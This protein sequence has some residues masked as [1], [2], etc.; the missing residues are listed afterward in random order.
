MKVQ[1]VRT[2]MIFNVMTKLWSMVSIYLFVPLYLNILGEAA[3][4]LISIFSTLQATLN[5]LGLGLS[6]TL[7]REFAVGEENDINNARKYKLLKS[8]ELI[9]A[10]IAIIIVALCLFGSSFIANEWLNI[11]NLDALQVSRVIVLMGV[12]I[13]LQLVAS[14]YSGCLLGLEHQA[15][16]NSYCIV[17]SALKSIGALLII[18]FVKTDL[19]YFYTWHITVDIVYILVLRITLRIKCPSNEKWRFKDLSNLKTIWKYTLGILIISFVALINRQYDKLIISKF[20]SITDV[21]AYNVA[22]TLGSI[23]AIIPS[24]LYT[25]MFPKFTN[26]V[27]TGDYDKLQTA[28]LGANRFTNIVLMCMGSFIAIYAQELIFVWTGSETYQE[29]LGLAGT[30]IV[31]AITFL[32]LQEIPYA[33][34]LSHGN[35]KTNIVVG[36]AFLPIVLVS[37]FLGVYF[38]GILGASIVY[39]VMMLSQSTAYLLLIYKKYLKLNK[40]PRVL[41]VDTLLPFFISIVM[42]IASKFLIGSITSNPYLQAGFAVLCGLVAL[43]IMYLFFIRNKTKEKGEKKYE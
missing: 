41:L 33:L 8:V 43:I 20:L 32:E 39:F 21:G 22:N 18:W 9:Y 2:N 28:F 37:M 34:A 42:A 15:L 29:K 19:V 11:E 38:Y 31:L 10:G 14:M 26:Y 35:T 7:G 40:V 4:G 6:N 30:F 24:A 25:T 17:W 27:S 3:Y 5:I 13:A 23:T 12:S 36:V 16:A 1:K